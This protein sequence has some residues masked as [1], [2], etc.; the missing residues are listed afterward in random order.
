MLRNFCF[1]INNYTEEEIEQIEKG[2]WWKYITYGKETG[3]NN[4]P[5][6]QGYCE[7]QKRTRFNTIKQ[8]LPRAHIE[9]RRGTQ[10]QAIV[11]CHKDGEFKELGEKG[12]QGRRKDLDKTREMALDEG[13]RAV[14]AICNFQ[15]IKVAEKFLTYNE[16]PREWKPKVYWIWGESGTGKSKMARE[17]CT[18]DTYTKNNGTK[19]WDGYDAHE[20]VIIDDFRESWWELTYMLALLDR[21]EFQVEI[22]G[23]LRQFK[24]KQIIITSCYSPDTVYDTTENIDQLLRR[25]DD[26]IF[27]GNVPDVPEVEG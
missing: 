7:L 23:G 18:E 1:T 19:W 27:L 6:L 3:E 21:Y 24:P 12:E 14:T 25:V 15:Q 10:E 13:M 16:E 20:N 11:Y 26:V 5:H 2:T 4:T 17:I 9:G 22:K 8:Y